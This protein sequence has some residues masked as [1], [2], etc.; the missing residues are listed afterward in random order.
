MTS[1]SKMM[2]LNQSIA[3]AVDVDLMKVPGFSLD[4]LMV[5]CGFSIQSLTDRI[6]SFQNFRRSL[7]FQ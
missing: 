2:F 1:F 7:G 3:K 4:Q 6:D 5:S